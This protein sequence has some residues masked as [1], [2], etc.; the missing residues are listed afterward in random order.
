MCVCERE[1]EMH[2][3]GGLWVAALLCDT[4]NKVCI[5][6]VYVCGKE[7]ARRVDV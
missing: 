4:S 1:R 2:H 3:M 5:V 6:F 7:G